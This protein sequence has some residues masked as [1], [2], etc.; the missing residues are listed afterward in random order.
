M[1]IS[2]VSKKYLAKGTPSQYS[3]K[4]NVIIFE[5]IHGKERE[6][7]GGLSSFLECNGPFLH[8]SWSFSSPV[9]LCASLLTLSS[10]CPPYSIIS[11]CYIRDHFPHFLGNFLLSSQ[12]IW[13]F[14]SCL[15][16]CGPTESS[17]MTMFSVLQRS[18]HQLHLNT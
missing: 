8:L 13:R 2:F 16:Q 6:T 3:L 10:Y 9:S 17:V 14:I 18:R 11:L 15:N 1:K 7:S 12:V 5:S 4:L